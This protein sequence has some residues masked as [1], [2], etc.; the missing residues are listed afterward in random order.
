MPPA[1]SFTGNR[2]IL[3]GDVEGDLNS[4]IAMINDTCQPAQNPLL[5][6]P[7]TVPHPAGASGQTTA[8]LPSGSADYN[9]IVNWI[10]TGCTNP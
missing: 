5:L 8:V 3:T 10:R 1:T 4:T 6:R 2:Y 7:S 9:T